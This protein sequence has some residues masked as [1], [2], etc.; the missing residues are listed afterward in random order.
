MH[1]AGC[2]VDLVDNHLPQI[3][4]LGHANLADMD[5]HIIQISIILHIRHDQ[6]ID[7]RHDI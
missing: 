2:L 1:G 4:R 7:M 6:G 3:L 5:R